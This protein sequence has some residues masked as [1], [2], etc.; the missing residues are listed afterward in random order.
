MDKKFKERRSRTCETI[1]HEETKKTHYV[2]A[3][4]IPGNGPIKTQICTLKTSNSSETF[5]AINCDAFGPD[6]LT[7]ITTTNEYE[8]PNG[9][10]T[11]LGWTGVT[12]LATWQLF[13]L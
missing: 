11:Q 1:E 13:Y 3:A 8:R 9:K 5:D 10:T 2:L 6:R 12:L 7:L 4:A